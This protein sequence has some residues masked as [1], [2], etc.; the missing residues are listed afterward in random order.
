MKF[1]LLLIIFYFSFSYVRADSVDEN[2]IHASHVGGVS[3]NSDDEV[4][5]VYLDNLIG[6]DGCL[7]SYFMW[8]MAESYNEDEILTFLIYAHGAS[9]KVNFGVDGDCT[10][11]IPMF[12]YISF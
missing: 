7:R 5:Y 9:K 1:S 8:G 4:C 6:E 2:Y 12:E 10:K 11:E 3:C